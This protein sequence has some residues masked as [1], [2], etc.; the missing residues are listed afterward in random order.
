MTRLQTCLPELARKLRQ[1]S[2]A[3]QRAASLAACQF[4]VCRAG[5]KNS[6][7]DETLETMRSGGTLPLK[8]RGEIEAL[9]AELDD[10]YLDL[11]EAAEEGRAKRGDYMRLFA[12]ARAV[13]A[14][15]LALKDDPFEAAAEAIYEAVESIDEPDELLSMIDA[16]LR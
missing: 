15:L 7:V 6:A 10:K 12:Q 8:K 9:A 2:Q 16:V 3:K 14:V 13:S 1:V 5:V 11:Q 4:A